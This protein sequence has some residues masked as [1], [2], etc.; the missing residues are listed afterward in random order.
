MRLCYFKIFLCVQLQ[1]SFNHLTPMI[2]LDD[3][4]KW[5]NFLKDCSPLNWYPKSVGALVIERLSRQ[6]KSFRVFPPMCIFTRKLSAW[7]M[8]QI[9]IIGR[10]ISDN[11]TN[12]QSKLKPHKLEFRLRVYQLN[13]FPMPNQI[14]LSNRETPK[15]PIR[16]KK[17][18][19]KRVNITEILCNSWSKINSSLFQKLENIKLFWPF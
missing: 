7:K 1:Q 16:S 8:V 11:E 9:S 17:L 10:N 6:T 19:K 14:L 18:S 12:I 5:D 13:I 4:L 3:R 2:N 15:K